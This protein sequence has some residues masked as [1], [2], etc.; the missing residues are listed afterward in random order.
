MMALLCD[1][2]PARY[3]RRGDAALAGAF[4]HM[5]HR[6]ALSVR[7]WLELTPPRFNKNGFPVASQH[8]RQKGY[9]FYSAYSLLIASQFGFAHLL[10]GET[11][12]ERP[13]PCDIG[14]YVLRLRDAFHKVFEK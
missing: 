1:Y 2:E 13:A 6:A 7:R 9:G 14:G 3:R 12:E 4:Q 8:G 5:A 10:A 11:A